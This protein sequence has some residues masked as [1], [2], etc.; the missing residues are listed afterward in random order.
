MCADPLTEE[1]WKRMKPLEDPEGS[2]P[3][4][5]EILSSLRKEIDADTTLL[6]FVGSPWTLTA[7]AVEGKADRHCKRTKV[8]A[9]DLALRV[10]HTVL[11]ID[12]CVPQCRVQ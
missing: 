9:R 10:S 11:L 1:N 4:I 3:F 2:L 8:S 7:Y 6:G 12:S 5:K